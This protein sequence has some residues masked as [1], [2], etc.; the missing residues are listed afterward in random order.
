MTPRV[1]DALAEWA[2]GSDA[3][4]LD[5]A[6]QAAWA[7]SARGRDDPQGFRRFY[8]L[9][10]GRDLPAHARRE[11]LPAIYRA[12]RAGQGVVIEAFRGSGKTTTLTLGWLAFRAGH[13]PQ[14]SHLLVQGSGASARHNAR[15]IAELIRQHPAWALAFPFV[16]PDDEAG[17]GLEGYSLRRTDLPPH[18]WQALAL[19]G[20]GKDPTLLGLGHHSRA[21][22]GRHPTGT[23]LVD[24]LHDEHNSRPGRELE[25]TL[26]IL[27][28]T[29]L[30]AALPQTWQ[31][32]IGTPWSEDDAL[33][34]LKASGEYAS[35]RTPALRDGKPV[36]P[37]V[38]GVREIEKMRALAGSVE[39]GRMYLLDLSAAHGGTLRPEW[40]GT[41]SRH[42]IDPRWPALMGVDYASAA[43][44][45]KPGDYFALAL[46]RVLPH[47]GVVLED[48]LR[49]RLSQAEAEQ[50]VLEWA[51]RHPSLREIVVEGD[52]RGQDFYQLL[53]RTSG[54]P[55][56]MKKT[57]GRSKAHRFEREMAPQFERR[58]AWLADGETPFLRAFRE[59]WAQFPRGR[60][61][62]TLDAAFW[63]LTAGLPEMQRAYAP[64]RPPRGVNPFFAGFGRAAGSR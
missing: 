14:H 33:A 12:G 28:G 7:A 46:G 35:V 1:D 53:L 21:L 55:L 18:E 30:P 25:T 27:T 51:S 45:G 64:P 61:D 41:I 26:D 40:L 13:H 32:F 9:V 8:R 57:G 6:E 5:L 16:Q 37:G 50:S 38:F 2:A 39:F 59:E 47:G 42:E 19:A 58:M 34:R 63:M 20:R 48:G 49:A 15:Q 44:P 24:D 11:W 36:W 31:V 56:T 52:G 10:F 29:L 43:E 54:L 4:A 3:A 62:D 23:L 60:H 22:I 17:W